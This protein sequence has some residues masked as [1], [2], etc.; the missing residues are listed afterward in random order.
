MISVVVVIIS[1][2]VNGFWHLNKMGTCMQ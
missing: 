2:L 1:L